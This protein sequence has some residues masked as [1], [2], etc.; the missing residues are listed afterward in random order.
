MNWSSLF[1]E[2]LYIVTQIQGQH[3]YKYIFFTLYRLITIIK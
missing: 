1:L 2:A 3:C